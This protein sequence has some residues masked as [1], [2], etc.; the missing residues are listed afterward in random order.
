MA[1]GKRTPALFEII[2]RA[3]TEGQDPH[4]QVPGWW[5]NFSEQAE[6]DKDLGPLSVYDADSP[7]GESDRANYEAVAEAVEIAVAEVVTEPVAEEALA[8]PEGEDSTAISD[9]VDDD[10][11]D[12]GNVVEVGFMGLMRT[13]AKSLLSPEGG[14]IEITLGLGGIVVAGVVGL[15]M[16]S[17]S[18]AFGH[19]LGQKVGSERTS[20]EMQ[21]EV[22]DGVEAARR[23]QAQPEVLG[24]GGDRV[25]GKPSAQVRGPRPSAPTP[26]PAPSVAA[27]KGD[28]PPSPARVSVDRQVGWNYLVVQSFRGPDSLAEAKKAKRFV[29]ATMAGQGGVPPVTVEELP[30]GGHLLLSTIGYPPGDA[31]F[32]QALARF[33]EQIRRV[34]KAYQQHG[35][36]YDFR[37]AYP[38][39]LSRVSKRRD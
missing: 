16:L 15:A 12:S 30:S 10:R 36:G 34:G 33:K 20:S 31:N 18:F 6:T 35:G 23:S 26:A 24:L 9:E 17:V 5:R 38:M 11:A 7:A 25:G 4:L 1:K 8:E 21:E 39:R 32:K 14:R 3:Q 29:L 2:N 28:S 19:E 37:D 27:K 22:V 13:K